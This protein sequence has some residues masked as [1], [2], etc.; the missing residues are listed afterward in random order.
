MTPNDIPESSTIELIQ[1]SFR[2]IGK[3]KEAEAIEQQMRAKG[4]SVPP[5]GGPQVLAMEPTYQIL[6]DLYF[7]LI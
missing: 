3:V 5:S 7:D 1:F 6:N 4:G 2:S